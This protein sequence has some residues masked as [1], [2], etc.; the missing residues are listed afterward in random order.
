MAERLVYICGARFFYNPACRFSRR[1]F[2]S[3]ITPLL[4]LYPQAKDRKLKP[5]PIKALCRAGPSVC[6]FWAER[7]PV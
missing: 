3:E 7:L 1:L 4:S 2:M 6:Q 5:L